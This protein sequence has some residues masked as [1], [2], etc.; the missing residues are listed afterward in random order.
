M[1]KVVKFNFSATKNLPQ[2]WLFPFLL[3]ISSIHNNRTNIKNRFQLANNNNFNWIQSDFMRWELRNIEM[4]KREVEKKL[5]SIVWQN[6]NSQRAMTC[7]TCI[8]R[9]DSLLGGSKNAFSRRSWSEINN[10]WMTLRTALCELH[11]VGMIIVLLNV[12]I[13]IIII[14]VEISRSLLK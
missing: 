4:I 13:G 12:H 14:S 3:Y 10:L 8:F 11:R 1:K 9:Y 6:T 7:D 2:L 5:S